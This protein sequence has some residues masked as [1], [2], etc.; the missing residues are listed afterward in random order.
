MYHL[1]EVAAFAAILLKHKL[2]S[3]AHS[4]HDHELSMSEEYLLIRFAKKVW[5]EQMYYTNTLHHTTISNRHVLNPSSVL[6]YQFVALVQ[7]YC[8]SNCK[9]LLYYSN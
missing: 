4:I 2:C 7:Q 1:S 8:I 6:C 3:I 5:K 9:V